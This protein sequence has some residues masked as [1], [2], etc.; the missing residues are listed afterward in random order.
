MTGC[1][2]AHA[3]NGNNNSKIRKNRKPA[4]AAE[5]KKERNSLSS[6]QPQVVFVT[7]SN[8]FVKYNPVEEEEDF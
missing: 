8:F 4:T 5:S 2:S 1:R 3:V 7:V 6:E